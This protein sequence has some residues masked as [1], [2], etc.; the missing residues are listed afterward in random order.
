MEGAWEWLRKDNDQLHRA[1]RADACQRLLEAFKS[2]GYCI[3]QDG[4]DISPPVKFTQMAKMIAGTR[5][6]SVSRGLPPLPKD[7]RHALVL[8]YGQGVTPIEKASTMA[9]EGYKPATVSAASAYHAGGG[10]TSGGRHALEEAFCSQSTLYPS[11]EKGRE[12]WKAGAEKNWWKRSHPSHEQHI[13]ED[14]CILSPHVEIFRGNTD[15]GYF[16]HNRTVP[17]TAVVSVAM[18]NKNSR[19]RDAPVDA[20]ADEVE[21][22]KGVREKF[23]AMIHAAALAGADAVIIPDVGC[24]VFQNDPHLCGRIC[25]EV[26]FNYSS[27]FKRA[28][29]TGKSAFFAEAQEALAKASS[30]G[31][32]P[33]TADLDQRG[34]VMP[35]DSKAHLY[36]GKCCACGRGL[37]GVDF[38]D[39]AIL[40]DKS[41]K[42]TQMQFL[43]ASCATAARSMFPKHQIMM[44]PDITRNAKSFF[45]ALDLNGNGFIEKDE[46]RCVCALLWDGDVATEAEAFE[47]DFSKRFDKWDADQS[48]HLIAKEVTGAAVPKSG[49]SGK[50]VAKESAAATRIP[51]RKPS[52]GL[53]VESLED[54]SCLEWFQEQARRRSQM[55]NNSASGSG[56]R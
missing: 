6:L 11:L 19:V 54:H 1:T 41:L 10:F 43:H 4:R 13:P 28:V 27:R 56:S 15:Q 20:P 5:M 2:G 37:D 35:V 22:E 40:L 48:G 44:L 42:S 36:I 38:N 55:K 25:G 24:G 50:A 39:L 21:Y 7:P 46:L 47:E 8:E 26:L 31:I 23:T 16:A 29:F 52:R 17:I 30:G 14:G 9:L 49:A 53:C 45:R 34:S 3:T 33:I 18:F 51:S 12:L 32:M